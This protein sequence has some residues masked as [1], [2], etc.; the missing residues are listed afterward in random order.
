[1]LRMLALGSA[2]WMVGCSSL[3]AAPA[4]PAE[5]SPKNIIVFI[6]DGGGYN[7][8][9]ATAMWEGKP[10]AWQ[11]RGWF[12]VSVATYA[13]RHGQRAPRGTDLLSQDPSQV[14]DPAKAWDAAPMEGQAGGYP[15]AYAGYRWLRATAPDSANT[16]SAIFTGVTTYTGAINVDGAM[17]PV[18]TAAEVA[19][20]AGKAVGVVTSVPFSHATPAA[21]GGAHNPTRE[22]YHGIAAEMLSA[23]VCDFIGGAGHPGFDN[24]GQPREPKF[25]WIAEGAFSSL[26]AGTWRD[27]AGRAWTMVDQTDAI[28]G[29]AEGDPAGPVI[30]LA[31]VAD[32]LQ[33][34][35]RSAGDPKATAPG[36]DP[37]TPGL[38]TLVDLAMAGFNAVDED[39]EGF[40]LMVEGGAV[41]WAMHANQCG[42]MIEEMLEFHQAIE[43][44]LA[45]LDAGTASPNPNDPSWENTLVLITADHDHLLVGPEGEKVAFQPLVDRGRGNV[46]GHR[47]MSNGHSNRPVPLWAAGAG[48]SRFESIATLED[49]TSV[50]G[51]PVGRGA[52]FHQSEIGKA[53]CELLVGTSEQAH[54]AGTIPAR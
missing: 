22:D 1:M 45:R 48:R 33:M 46:P 51:V 3:S 2:A 31:P 50:G 49:Q 38:P 11:S 42:R 52:Y 21:A 18:R 16:A 6:A 5:A 15:F 10:P 34:E 43:A 19:K 25:E 26:R 35:R 32:T 24:D 53:I 39:P 41:D 20:A 37:L 17:Q 40:L 4:V 12:E 54:R 23:G 47:W 27:K 9:L 29:L 28:R 13:L 7:A 8:H 14:F 36:V 44:T 30:A